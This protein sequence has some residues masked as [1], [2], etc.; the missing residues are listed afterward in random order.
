[1]CCSNHDF[2]DDSSSNKECCKFISFTGFFL[3]ASTIFIILTIV[4]FTFLLYFGVAAII[5]LTFYLF[6]H[7]WLALFSKN[8]YDI[9]LSIFSN[10]SEFGLIF[11]LL[12]M[13]VF[14]IQKYI[15]ISKKN[16]RSSF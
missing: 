3:N 16:N 1:M 12:I 5:L 15:D 2:E 6:L 10:F 11:T 14:I 4:V 9:I 13:I 8:I 7:E